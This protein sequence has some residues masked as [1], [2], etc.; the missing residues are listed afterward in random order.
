ML[1]TGVKDQISEQDAPNIPI[2]WE[3]RVL[4]A[5]S[6]EWGQRPNIYTADP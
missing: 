3:I 1:G 5:L 2:T 6:Q 4:G